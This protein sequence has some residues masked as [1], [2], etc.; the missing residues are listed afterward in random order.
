M[1]VLYYEWTGHTRLLLEWEWKGDNHDAP[2]GL[3]NGKQN[4]DGRWICHGT[5]PQPVKPRISRSKV[6]KKYLRGIATAACAG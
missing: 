6:I 1:Q 2:S 3:S 5:I 4:L